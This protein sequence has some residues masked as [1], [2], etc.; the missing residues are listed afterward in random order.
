VQV[1]AF[2][3]F[4]HVLS[5]SVWV[6]G[7]LVLAGLLSTVRSLGDDAPRRVAQAFN[8]LAWPAF[9]IAVVTGLW[10]VVAIPLSDLQHPWIEIKVLVVLLSGLGAAAHQMARGNKIVLA[11]GGAMSSLFAIAAMYTGFLVTPVP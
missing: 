6:G 10:N 9:G 8:R 5:A 2:R 4:L 1:T 11:V 7:Q 3:L